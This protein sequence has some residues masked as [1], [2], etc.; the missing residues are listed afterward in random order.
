[1]A[2]IGEISAFNMLFKFIIV[3]EDYIEDSDLAP[4]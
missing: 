2:K 3:E 4:P 1:L